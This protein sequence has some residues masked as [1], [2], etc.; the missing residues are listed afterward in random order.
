MFPT[1]NKAAP[2][3]R[4]GATL[5]TPDWFAMKARCARLKREL[6]ANRKLMGV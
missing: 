3:H 6:K 5:C 4:T 2:K 1:I